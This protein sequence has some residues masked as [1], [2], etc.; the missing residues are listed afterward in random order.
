MF[1]NETESGA[2]ESQVATTAFWDYE[3]AIQKGIGRFLGRWLSGKENRLL[4]LDEYLRCHRPTQR[5]DIGLETVAIEQIKGS[6]ERSE[7]FDGAF[8]PLQGHTSSR[9]MSIDRA[10]HRSSP[11]PPV[12]LWKVGGIYFVADGHHRI[13]VAS[14]HRQ[15]YIDAHVI[16][17]EVEKHC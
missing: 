17:I 6:I 14:L 7:D 5:Q 2:A 11:L 12:D 16:N 9:W 4:S 13:S 15:A 8:M 1:I 3:R 10:Y